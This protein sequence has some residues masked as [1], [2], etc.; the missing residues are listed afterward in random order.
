MIK[1]LIK[2]D[3]TTVNTYAPNIEASQ[4]IRQMLTVI[5]GEIDSNTIFQQHKRRLYTWISPDGQH[6]NHTDYILCSQRWRSSI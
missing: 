3:V 1:G 6:R 5:K 4:Y 2:E